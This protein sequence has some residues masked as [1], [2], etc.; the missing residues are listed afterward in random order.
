MRKFCVLATVLCCVVSSTWAQITLKGKVVDAKSGNP[1]IGATVRLEQ[2]TIG[3]ATDA[4]GEFVIRNVANGNYVVRASFAGYQPSTEKV[5]AS[6]DGIFFKLKAA[7]V[8]LDQVVVTGTGTHR[9]LKDSPVPVE[10]LNAVDIKKA[11]LATVEDALTMLN[12]SFDFR[13]TA[14][15]SNLTL[16]GLSNK[17]I[18]IMVNGKRMN[19]DISGNTDLSRIDMSRVKRIEIV[20]G[21]ASSLYGS[22]AMA[23]VI[24]IITDQPHDLLNVVSQTRFGGNS[25]F[26][27]NVNADVNAGKFSSST[28]YQRRQ[29]DGWRLSD[30]SEK[31][32]DSTK[33][34]SDKFHSNF[35]SQRFAYDVTKRLSFYAQG[36]YFDKEVNRLPS[37]FAYDLSY[38]NYNTGIGGKYLF[39]NA[40]YVTMD[41]YMDNYEYSYLYIKKSGKIEVGDEVLTKRQRNVN[42]NLRG[43]FKVG[44]YN[45]FTVGMDFLNDYLKNPASLDES[46][47]AYTLSFYAQD[48]IRL[49]EKF[50]LIP[51]FRYVYHET[52]GNHF[53]PKLAA[54]YSLNKFNFRASYAAGFKAPRLEELYYYKEK[55]GTL[56][57]G[58]PDLKP[59]KSNYFSLNAEYTG[60]ILN[61]SVSGY[62][63]NIDYIITS[64]DVPLTPEEEGQGYDKKKLYVNV[65]KARVQGID[66]V[67][68]SYVGAGFS[69][70]GG[71]SYV[72]A[73]DRNA[74]VRL[75]GTVKHTGTVKAGWLREWNKYRLNVNVN[76]RIQG[77]KYFSTTDKKGN[78]VDES[79]VK[80]N[81]WNLTTNHNF[82]AVGNFL[83]EVNLGIDNVF[84]FVDDRPYG[85]NYATL[86]PGR[87][88]FAGLIIRFKK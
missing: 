56:S 65:D 80:Y 59:E 26:I 48:E 66:V 46:K 54:M 79:A 5:N 40:A 4:K 60:R 21:A 84:D 68:N 85:V 43:V 62:I 71:Y 70:G 32:A 16:N 3:T 8:D 86:T 19:G 77:E 49:W 72:D 2:T 76:G 67:L 10:V 52:F 6:R 73:K 63:N 78:I 17:Y 13:P 30:E 61:A 83:F 34:V 29:A 55:S 50:Q 87:T 42:G 81:L 69:I 22:D 57:V 39:G 47:S 27:Q 7:P 24:N 1:L 11:G 23:G 33:Q 31:A 64:K 58:N 44:S 51:G 82:G 9:R 53:T 14:M 28:S 74:D 12:P 36:S 41:V 75:E 25:S 35:I 37:A 38:L 15:G 45:K 88:F 20:K 18:L